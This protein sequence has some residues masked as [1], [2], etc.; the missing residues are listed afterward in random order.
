METQEILQYLGFAVLILFFGFTIYYFFFN[1][2]T[3]NENDKLFFSFLKII[4]FPTG[5]FIVNYLITE[6]YSEGF[7]RYFEI[8]DASGNVK[9]ISDQMYFDLKKKNNF[10]NGFVGNLMPNFFTEHSNL[11]LLINL[12]LMSSFFFLYYNNFFESLKNFSLTSISENFFN[13]KYFSESVLGLIIVFFGLFKFFNLSY[14]NFKVKFKFSFISLLVNSI[15]SV[16]KEITNFLISFRTISSPRIQNIFNKIFSLMFS[17]RFILLKKYTDSENPANNQESEV[18]MKFDDVGV[19]I[20]NIP[21]INISQEDI[22]ND[23]AGAKIFGENTPEFLKEVERINEIIIFFNRIKGMIGFP[24]Q[25]FDHLS[26]DQRNDSTHDSP[27]IS[28]P[29]FIDEMIANTNV[30]ENRDGSR[31]DAVISFSD[32][33]EYDE[34]K[35]N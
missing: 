16:F 20:N 2:S 10:L 6:Y 28:F 35:Y 4:S 17:P 18:F 5:A 19:L 34:F 21:T 7:S 8:K 25:I 1:D 24:G 31:Y 30:P 13:F 15:S 14:Q 11:N 29:N 9:K 27:K 12:F 32:V 3:G 23:A 26:T 22:D 33:N